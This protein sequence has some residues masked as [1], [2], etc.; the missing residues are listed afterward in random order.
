MAPTPMT[1][2][3][4]YGGMLVNRAYDPFSPLQHAVPGMP[5]YPRYP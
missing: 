4:G 3:G 5:A 1:D 2:A